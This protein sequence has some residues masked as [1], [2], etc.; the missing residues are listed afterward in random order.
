MFSAQGAQAKP[1]RS[2]SY[3][4]WMVVSNIFYLHPYLGKWSNL[5][6]I[7]ADGLVQPPTS[8]YI[9]ILIYASGT[10]TT[11]RSIDPHPFAGESIENIPKVRRGTRCP[12]DEF[13]DP[14]GGRGQ[15]LVVQTSWAFLGNLCIICVDSEVDASFS[16]ACECLRL[17]S[18]SRCLDVFCVWICWI[19][20]NWQ[21]CLTSV[22]DLHVKNVFFFF[23][24]EVC[25]HSFCWIPHFCWKG[26][27][28][29]VSLLLL[30]C[31]RYSRAT[32]RDM[33]L[34]LWVVSEHFGDSFLEIKLNLDIS[35]QAYF[36]V[37][38]LPLKKLRYLFCVVWSIHVIPALSKARG[39]T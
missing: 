5:T 7:F 37:S 38:A 28:M 8:Y 11:R 36:A 17:G 31:S 27:K 30:R 18:L 35:D 32:E 23:E 24:W 26:R 1:L 2:N 33:Q 16:D 22:V 14:F 29:N 10:I 21:Q 3:T 20:Q 4:I 34:E 12:P 13:L 39:I 6:N 25:F 15:G 19:F 9:D